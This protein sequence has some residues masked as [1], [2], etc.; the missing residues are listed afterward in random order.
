M[1]YVLIV[2]RLKT[3]RAIFQ[4]P[5]SEIEFTYVRSSGPGGQN[6]NKV[7]SKAVA[8]WGLVAS[9]SVTEVQRARLLLRLGSRLTC[10]G[11]LLLASDRFRHQGRNRADCIEK[12][13]RLIAEA[14]EEPKER[15]A[16]TPTRSS[17]R[18]RRESKV[19][20][21]EKKRLREKVR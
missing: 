18:R 12:L 3:R 7:N 21:S 2:D 5:L 13:A 14:V 20:S 8:R 16:T 4:I 1:C 15:R 9:P 6:V 17:Q 11:E 19:R 10:E